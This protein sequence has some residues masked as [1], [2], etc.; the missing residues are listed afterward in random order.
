MPRSGY[1]AMVRCKLCPCVV[2]CPFYRQ[3]SSP[4]LRCTCCARILFLQRIVVDTGFRVVVVLVL[5]VLVALLVV[6]EV[7]VDGVVL[8]ML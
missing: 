4:V 2:L 6:V 5:V 3:R 1:T 8:N 7:V